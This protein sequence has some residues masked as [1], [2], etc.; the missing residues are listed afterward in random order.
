MPTDVFARVVTPWVD[1]ARADL[2]KGLS[3]LPDTAV[4]SSA[5]VDACAER[6]TSR[7]T[8]LAAPVLVHELSRATGLLGENGH[9]RFEH[10]LAR[11]HFGPYPVLVRE[12]DAER[13]TTVEVVVEIATRYAA[14]QERLS[15]TVLGAKAAL[16]DVEP[17]GDRHQG[18]RAT[19]VLWLADGQRVVYKP[20]GV[21]AHLALARVVELVN[22]LVD[23]DLATVGAVAGDD[24]GWTEFVEPAPLPT[25]DAGPYFRRLGGLLAVLHLVRATDMHHENLITRADQPLLIDVET[26]FRP[27]LPGTPADPA[28]VALDRSVARTGILPALA[29]RHGLVDLSAVGG[30]AGQQTSGT[31]THW[32]DTGTDAMRAVLRPEHT[33]GAANRPTWRG[34]PVEAAAHTDAVLAGFRQTYDAIGFHREEF[35]RVLT[36]CGALPVR[37][38]P[39]PAARYA[40]LL[41]TARR[42]AMMRDA[43]TRF[44]TLEHAC[45]ALLPALAPAEAAELDAGDVPLFTA[46]ADGRDLESARGRLPGVL[47]TSGLE[48]ALTCLAAFD[49]ADRADQ[50]WVIAAS[51]ATR[52]P[53]TIGVVRNRQAWATDDVLSTT[54]AIA[55]RI[56][57]LGCGTGRVNWIG[58]EPA[59]GARWL[60]LPMG[61][62]LAHGYP[63]VALFLAQLGRITGDHR[64]TGVARR[65]LT[66]VPEFLAA[67]QDND[68]LIAEVGSGGLTGFAGIGYA[69]ARIARLLDDEQVARWARTTVR[70]ADLAAEVAAPEHG[71]ASAMRALDAEVGSSYARELAEHFPDGPTGPVQW[72]PHGASAWTDEDLSLCHGKLGHADVSVDGWSAATRHRRTDE[73]LAELGR[74]GPRCVTPGQ[75]PTPGLLSGLAGLGMGLLRLGF[76]DRTPSVLRFDPAN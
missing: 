63:G 2:R 23:L 6:L 20:R 76:P 42:P 58:L 27:G 45:A 74:H 55:D 53:A 1:A 69:L 70:L 21:D 49:E 4:T 57:A 3:S 50:E 17:R 39:R 61:P 10:F 51:L 38:V 73:V 35:A 7:L 33:P 68:E 46:R 11:R 5:L 65:A 44:E 34:R 66:D 25:G 28:A 67:L 62:G 64:Y 26:L 13:D 19:S 60:V 40:Q 71:L 56:I 41:A 54:C 18:G 22:H 37:I 32:L 24:H 15:G 29:G 16:V 14:D 48:D 72:C 52:L 59:G 30:D 31:T 36:T 12:L 9:E 47:A 8:R 75:V 43:D